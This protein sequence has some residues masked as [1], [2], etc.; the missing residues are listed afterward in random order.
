M[1]PSLF[2]NWGFQKLRSF[3]L[4]EIIRD[5]K[6]LGENWGKEAAAIQLNF[7]F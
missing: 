6:E 4:C 2:H 5:D 7:D 3:L 1:D